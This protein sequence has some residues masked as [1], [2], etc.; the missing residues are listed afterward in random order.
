MSIAGCR[1]AHFFTDVGLYVLL[2][3]IVLVEGPDAQALTALAV[4]LGVVLVLI[5][6]ARTIADEGDRAAALAGE[7]R[8]I[9]SS[10]FRD[11]DGK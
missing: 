3:L 2:P 5:W 11:E 8:L 7:L 1:P 4:A 10:G 9:R 6:A